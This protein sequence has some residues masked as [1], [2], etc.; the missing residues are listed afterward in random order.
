[1]E[2]LILTGPE[3]AFV[4]IF[5]FPFFLIV[6]FLFSRN[7]FLR[8]FQILNLQRKSGADIARVLLR[9]SALNDISIESVCGSINDSFS[10]QEHTVYLSEY[11]YMSTSLAA[12]CI[13][14]HEVGHAIQCCHQ[15]GVLLALRK[16]LFD[17]TRKI[18]SVIG[19]LGL[20]G[21]FLLLI[22]QNAGVVTLFSSGF[23]FFLWLFLLCLVSFFVEFNA[24]VLAVRL[25]LR[26]GFISKNELK[27]VLFLYLY[28]LI[29]HLYS[30]ISSFLARELLNMQ[31]KK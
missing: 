14:A 13:S 31:A 2:G 10:S 29:R 5:P 20:S 21:F 26:F 12:A 18:F 30:S 28:A 15:S 6:V 3:L 17:L 22:S 9:Q 7:Q 24:S 19:L 11:V 23:L 25:L 4:C 16:C 1:M 27:R 8:S